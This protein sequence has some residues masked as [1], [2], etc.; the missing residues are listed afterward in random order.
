MNRIIIL[1]L[2]FLG[3]SQLSFSQYDPAALEIL[4]AMSKKY[5]QITAFKADIIYSLVNETEG[6]NDNFKGNVVVKGDM[7]KLVMDEQEI[8]NNGKTVWTYL[9][10]VNEVTIDNYNPDNAYIN[11]TKI[12]NAYKKGFKYLYLN[13]VTEDGKTFQMV[14]LVPEN[15]K[16][17]QYFKIRLEVNKDDKLLKAWTMFD[18]SGNKYVYNVENFT[19]NVNPGD[20]FFTFDPSKY[21]DIEIIDLR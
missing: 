8:V 19:T 17:S 21:K 14:D 15:A 3:I 4:E 20:A 11:P 5:Q 16:D 6:I 10:D 9:P 12:L 13:D 2:F 7:Y 1:I 18:K